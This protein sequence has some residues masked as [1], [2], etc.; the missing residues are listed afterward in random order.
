V[1]AGHLHWYR[2]LQAWHTGSV[3]AIESA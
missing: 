1:T 3:I 2:F